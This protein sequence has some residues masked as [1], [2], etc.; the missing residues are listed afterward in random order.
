MCVWAPGPPADE[1]GQ[2]LTAEL[3][4][5][6][7]G[8]G[9]KHEK[10]K[11]VSERSGEGGPELTADVAHQIKGSVGPDTL[12]NYTQ[13]PIPASWVPHRPSL[14]GFKTNRN[15]FYNRQIFCLRAVRLKGK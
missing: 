6:C 4:A 11:R 15:F 8:Q 7:A 10:R 1:E 5:P 12:H 13:H 9:D 14:M 3:P 2:I